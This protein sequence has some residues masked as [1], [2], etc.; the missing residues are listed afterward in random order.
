MADP[1]QAAA[2]QY[3]RRFPKADAPKP[4]PRGIFFVPPEVEMDTMH[5]QMVLLK[6]RTQEFGRAVMGALTDSFGPR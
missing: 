6:V 2:D 3:R 4:K 1:L 5:G